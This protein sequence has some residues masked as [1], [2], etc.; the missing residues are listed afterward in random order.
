MNR[1][2]LIL[3]VLGLGIGMACWNVRSGRI[4]SRAKTLPASDSNRPASATLFEDATLGAGISFFLDPG[5]LALY[6]V[7]QIMGSGCAF[8]D[9]D[10]DGRLDIFLVNQAGGAGYPDLHELPQSAASKPISRLFRQQADGS[11][12]DVT[13]G[14]GLDVVGVGMGVAVG[15]VNNDGFPDICVTY[16][17]GTRLFLNRRN[18]T[19]ADISEPAGIDNPLWGTS[20]AFLDFD[21][22]GWLDLFVAN[23]IDYHTGRRCSDSSGER[24]FCPPSVFAGTSHK[25]FRNESGTLLDSRSEET[26]ENPGVRF[27]DVSRSSGIA[28][29]RGLGLGVVSADFDGDRWPDLFVANDQGANFLWINQH[30][31]TF[32]EQAVLRGAAYDLNGRPQANMGIALGDLDGDGRLDLL[33]THFDGEM[34][35]FY[36]NKSSRYVRREP[37]PAWGWECRACPTRRGVRPSSTRTTTATLIWPWST[38]ASRAGRAEARTAPDCQNIP[39]SPRP[40]GMCVRR[41]KPVLFE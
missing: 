27:S 12:T 18:G 4:S 3:I 31:G 24:E 16:F 22:D 37:P 20:C 38:A 14:S 17:R 11:F 7:P 29:H 40:D 15:D 39:Q 26:T 5:P 33:V 10:Q 1:R 2:V 25:P 6:E 8:L 13:R 30:D 21:R 19:F 32:L 36:L 41:A 34:N 23:Y 9:F 28:L 35:A